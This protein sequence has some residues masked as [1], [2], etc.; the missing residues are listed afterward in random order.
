VTFHDGSDCSDYDKQD[1]KGAHLKGLF[2]SISFRKCL[3]DFSW[4]RCP[5]YPEAGPSRGQAHAVGKQ[6]KSLTYINHDSLLAHLSQGEGSADGAPVEFNRAPDPVYSTPKNQNS[7]VV[8]GNIVRCCI[9]SRLII[10][11]AIIKGAAP[12][13][14]MRK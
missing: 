1:C 10:Q 14:R 9:I 2:D 13:S 12:S 5:G 7:V 6:N 3:S 11:L 8:E 4:G